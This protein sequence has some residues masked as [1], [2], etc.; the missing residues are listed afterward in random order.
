MKRLIVTSLIFI[1]SAYPA[2]KT[3]C[4]TSYG[5]CTYATTGVTDSAGL[6]A[7]FLDLSC[8][9]EL[10]IAPLQYT[11]S[12]MFLAQSCLGN[13]IT[14]TSMRK[15]WLPGPYQRITPSHAR[16]ISGVTG[17]TGNIPMICSNTEQSPIL[18]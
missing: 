1:L 2:V 9:D 16:P 8:G 5:T 14:V 15:A 13:P 3:V 11:V 17:S 10:D 7:A 12:S 6:Q 4:P 18:F